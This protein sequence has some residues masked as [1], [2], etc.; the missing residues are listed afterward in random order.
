[1]R[2]L[3]SV[4]FVALVA[5]ADVSADGASPAP[6]APPASAER[7][8]SPSVAE[9]IDTAVV[10]HVRELRGAW[11]STAWNGTWPS[12]RGLSDAELK[13]ELVALFD[14]LAE[15][16]ANAVFL[17]VRAESDAFYAS[18]L[19]PWSRF[20]SG[21][22]GVAPGFDPLAFAVEAAHA[23]GLELHAWINPYRALTSSEVAAA[24]NHVSKTLAAQKV[25]W[26]T[27]VWMDPGAPQVR[28]HVED[29]VRD[30]LARY[31]VDGLHFDDYFYPY[32]IAGEAFPDDVTYAAY[33][34]GGG[35][36][37]RLAWRRSNVDALVREVSEIVATE[38]PDVRFG[39]SPFGIYKPGTP[40]GVTGLDAYNVL[41]CD[42][43]KWIDQG[44]VD[45][46]APQ[47]YWPTTKTQQSFSALVSW[48]ATLAKSG[49]SIFAGHDLTKIGQADFPLSE[50]EAE[51]DLSRAERDHGLRGNVFF[52]AK[53]I[54]DD[55]LGIA[56]RL[57][58]KY[59]T[60]AVATPKL[61]TASGVLAPPKVTKSA[62]TVTLEPTTQTR[63]F[64]VYMQS[65]S[66]QPETWALRRLVPA[67][68]PST[69]LTLER[70]TWAI[71]AI[72]RRGL[73]SGGVVV[74]LR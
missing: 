73:E 61:A 23:R 22:Q 9:T 11:I 10:G 20:L 31:D 43:V 30:I 37:D 12:E 70:G 21:T 25:T 69:E 68:S 65:A 19:E 66:T 6:S 36:L 51:M 55:T 14:G 58:T 16:R 59:W 53:M 1:M 45:Y 35:T 50:Y 4:G 13:A 62:E 63:F 28:A 71:S 40:E 44:W 27:Q 47:L 3:R 24:P 17:Q 34:D 56:S 46:L 49:R 2:S 5:C 57:S 74:E 42:P 39:I 32:P 8:S 15:A 67:A 41:A 29:V 26:G 33:Q 54:A 48:W 18:S 64:A 52:T 38:R 72:D 60:T 7:P